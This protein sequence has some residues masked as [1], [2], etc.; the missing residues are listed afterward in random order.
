MI[1]GLNHVGISVAN[2]D[3]SIRFYREA[4]GLEVI[5]RCAFSGE[6]YDKILGISA[7]YGRVVL[8]GNGNL[9]LELFEFAPPQ[10]ARLPSERSVAELGIS[11]F[12]I[13]T[14]DIES[15][16]E[17]LKGCG[18][19]FHCPPLD[20]AGL[21]KATYGRDLDGNVFELW[22]RGPRSDEHQPAPSSS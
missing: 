2:L 12:C 7:A 5:A 13:E 18:A 16:Y 10:Q 19:T 1:R 15:E 3:R 9:Q 8:L 20:S 22:E 21:A 14:T 17:R 6:T 11:H 4:F